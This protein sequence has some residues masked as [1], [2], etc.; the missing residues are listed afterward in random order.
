MIKNIL[1]LLEHQAATMK[2]RTW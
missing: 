2:R 1:E